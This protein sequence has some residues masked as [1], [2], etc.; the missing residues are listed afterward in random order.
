MPSMET[1]ITIIVA[2]VLL[3]V[4]TGL[5]VWPMLCGKRPPDDG[6]E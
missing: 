2:W 5:V 4:F 1:A 3:S 6:G